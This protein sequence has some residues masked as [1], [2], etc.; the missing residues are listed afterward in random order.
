MRR[1]VLVN[2]ILKKHIKN[3]EPLA[4]KEENAGYRKRNLLRHKSHIVLFFVV[5]TLVCIILAVVF[6]T[7]REGELRAANSQETTVKNNGILTMEEVI[8]LFKEDRIE[9]ADFLNY[10]NGVMDRDTNEGILN[11]YVKFK[12]NYQE[13][14]F[15]L[16]VSYMKK[17]DKL[18][19][20]YLTQ[21]ET[22]DSVLLNTDEPWRYT[23]ITDIEQFLAMETSI[24]DWLT[25]TLPKG[26][27]L[28]DYNANIGID[29]GAVIE[30]RAYEVAGEWV[31]SGLPEWTAAGVIS[32]IKNAQDFIIFENG[33]IKGKY[34]YWNHTTEEK[35]E[36]VEG[37]DMP[38]ILYHG[39][40]DLYTG[41]ELGKLEE[42]GI[43]I[44]AADTTSDYWYI[45][46]AKEDSDVAYYLSLATNIFTKEQAIEIAKT[47]HFLE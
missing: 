11:Y 39:N 34:A 10:T 38:A 20:I 6:T 28:T 14:N 17:N 43:Y 23:P 16:G 25:I 19:A 24:S 44:D 21:E 13:R 7:I 9:K 33:Q 29:G 42:Q 5:V 30:P 31:E 40:H 15:I 46:F 12:L 4:S 27:T 41:A 8:L 1:S 2:K 37:L 47:V 18:D 26:Y 3:G 22:N 36:N 45:Y 32:R 35:I